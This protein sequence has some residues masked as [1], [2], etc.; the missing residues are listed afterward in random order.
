MRR[1]RHE[2]KISPYLARFSPNVRCFSLVVARK[3]VHVRLMA[4]HVRNAC[5]GAYISCISRQIG[6]IFLFS[7]SKTYIRAFSCHPKRAWQAILATPS[8]Q[9]I[10]MPRNPAAKAGQR[11]SKRKIGMRLLVLPTGCVAL[12]SHCRPRQCVGRPSVKIHYC[13]L[14]KHG[15]TFLGNSAL[16]LVN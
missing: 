11:R 2:Q 4:R 12:V 5:C 8:L 15:A 3:R 9:G 10:D 14:S 1:T 7:R 13:P 6:R 16:V